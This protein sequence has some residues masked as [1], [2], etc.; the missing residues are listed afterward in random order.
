VSILDAYY[1]HFGYDG[2]TYF[3]GKGRIVWRQGKP[4]RM[5]LVRTDTPLLAQDLHAVG[6]ATIVATDLAGEAWIIDPDDIAR[7][8]ER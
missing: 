5:V 2:R 1:T 4:P 8:V 3:I 7:R 6:E